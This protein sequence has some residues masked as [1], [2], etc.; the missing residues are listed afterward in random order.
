MI[1]IIILR[2]ELIDATFVDGILISLRELISGRRTSSPIRLHIDR[3]HIVL[4]IPIVGMKNPRHLSP[5][6]RKLLAGE[7][8]LIL[9]YILSGYQR[10]SRIHHAL[11]RA[12]LKSFGN[13]VCTH[14][15]KTRLPLRGKAHCRKNA[16]FLY[17]LEGFSIAI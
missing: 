8:R 7:K 11:A 1:V 2:L 4:S 13:I 17:Q 3:P 10:G 15:C 6:K 9:V 14:Q 12:R 5:I 16:T